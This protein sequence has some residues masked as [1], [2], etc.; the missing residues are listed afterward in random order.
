MR[1]WIILQSGHALGLNNHT[2]ANPPSHLSA[3]L[4]LNVDLM[5]QIEVFIVCTE[6]LV[7]TIVVGYQY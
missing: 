3:P 2:F 5:A 7:C 4:S 1:D 6:M